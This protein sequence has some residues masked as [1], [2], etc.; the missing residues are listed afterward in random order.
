[1]WA[2]VCDHESC[3]EWLWSIAH[4]QE[5]DL[6]LRYSPW[7]TIS[8]L[9]WAPHPAPWQPHGMAAYALHF[10]FHSF[11]SCHMTH[12]GKYLITAAELLPSLGSLGSP[13]S[14]ARPGR[15]EGPPQ[16]LSIP[17]Q[18]FKI[19]IPGEGRKVGSCTELRTDV[20][21]PPSID[22]TKQDNPTKP[23]FNSLDC[24]YTIPLA[25]VETCT[26]TTQLRSLFMEGSGERYE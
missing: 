17:L 18:K 14:V 26:S 15:A 11:H 8:H 22:K 9:P 25:P 12:S 21:Y 20:V 19:P 3:V 1:M 24:Y 7:F 5:I 23:F 6:N 13:P 2:S 16:C 10:L 4:T